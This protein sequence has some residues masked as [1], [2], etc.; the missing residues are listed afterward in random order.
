MELIGMNDIVKPKRCPFED[1]DISPFDGMS[2]TDGCCCD[3]AALMCRCGL[4][5]SM[6]ERWH[7]DAVWSE[8]PVYDCH[9][10]QAKEPDADKRAI[11]QERY[12]SD[13]WDEMEQDSL[14]EW[15][16]YNDSEDD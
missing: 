4:I 8:G 14:N 1:A 16:V 15:D 12:I 6:D 2:W 5:V 13:R 9:C 3:H 11:L 10:C 7:M